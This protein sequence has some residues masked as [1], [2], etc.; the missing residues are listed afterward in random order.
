MKTYFLPALGGAV[1]LSVLPA[2]APAALI[3]DQQGFVGNVGVNGGWSQ[4]VRQSFQPAA[5]NLAGVDVYLYEVAQWID[6][7]PG[8]STMANVSFSLFTAM[9]PEDFGYVANAPL[10]TGSFFLDTQGTRTGWAEFRFAPLPVTPDTYYVLQF[11]ADNGIFG[12]TT[13]SGYTRGQVLNPGLER[14]Y[15][16]LHFVT[17]TD[18]AF[19]SAVP[20]PAAAWLFGSGLL[21]LAGTARRRAQDDRPRAD[22]RRINRA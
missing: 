4:I 3:V 9:G 5:D 1:L 21:A 16:D 20:V 13:L 11:T 15:F 7:G 18:D 2:I 8:I 14:D 19:A 10:I 22:S 17:Y 12:V 6:G